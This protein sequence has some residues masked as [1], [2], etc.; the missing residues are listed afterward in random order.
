LFKKQHNQFIDFK[1]WF[2]RKKIARSPIFRLPKSD[3][4][5]SSLFFMETKGW[6]RSWRFFFLDRAHHWIAEKI[7]D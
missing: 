5:A 4:V 3:K 2:Y 1:E 6:C 7:A